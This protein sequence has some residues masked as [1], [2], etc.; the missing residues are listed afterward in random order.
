MTELPN[1]LGGAR[2]HFSWRGHDIAYVKRGDG[3]PMLLVHSIHACAWSMEWRNVVP[4]LSQ[5]FT[6]YSLDL[7]GFGASAH[8]PIHYTSRLYIDL[9]RDFIADVVA[10][11]TIV[12]GSSLGG[13]Y[14]IAMAAEHPELVR[15]VCAI[16]PAGVTRLT[17]P[18]NAANA[19]VEKLFRTPRVGKA[20]FSTLVSKPSIR[21]FLK[22]IYHDPRMLTDDVVDLFWQSA[23]QENA[24]LAPA[25]FVGMQL[26]CDIR[27]A[28]GTMRA[29]LM[30][31]WGAFASQTPLKESAPM[32]ALRP[33]AAF[34]VLP[35]ADL[36][37]EECPTEFVA[38]LLQ[39]AT[40]LD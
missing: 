11:P 27:H 40:T 13:T 33:D 4:A 38:A 32:R 39:F 22:G 25:A 23:H 16:G 37:H 36:P 12:V 6:T 34:S 24:R 29:P 31:A 18:G 2:S 5:R 17:A 9:L 10:A 28:L 26:N 8:P 20:L 21:L 30:L 1:P 35:A 14:A 19:L 7:L 15:A 3:P